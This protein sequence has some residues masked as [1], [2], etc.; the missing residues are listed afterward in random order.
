MRFYIAHRISLEDLNNI[1]QGEFMIQKDFVDPVL[2][3]AH[4]MIELLSE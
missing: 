3:V 4:E 1:P 2:H